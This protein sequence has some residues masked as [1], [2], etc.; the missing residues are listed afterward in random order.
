MASMQDHV[1]AVRSAQEDYE[2]AILRAW[3]EYQARVGNSFESFRHGDDA[4][5]MA[6]KTVRT[7]DYT[8]RG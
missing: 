6:M 4:P 8:D 3:E 2:A 1:M 7:V 5:Q